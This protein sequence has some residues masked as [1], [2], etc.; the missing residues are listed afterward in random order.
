M[1]STSVFNTHSAGCQKGHFCCFGFCSITRFCLEFPGDGWEVAG[2]QCSG[3]HR[4]MVASAITSC[5]VTKLKQLEFNVIY[6]RQK[7]KK[8]PG[9]GEVPHKPWSCSRGR[10]GQSELHRALGE[11][12]REGRDREGRDPRGRGRGQGGWAAGE[13]RTEGCDG[14]C[15]LA[16][17][18][19][20]FSQAQADLG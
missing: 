19:G 17:P 16:F 20:W 8:I 18:D 7:K 10:L 15:L 14:V 2:I 5:Q 4:S 1:V 3:V 9:P 13:R 12:A 6:S 11:A